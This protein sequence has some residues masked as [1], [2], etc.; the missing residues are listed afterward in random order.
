MNVLKKNTFSPVQVSNGLDEK[1]KR[2]DSVVWKKSV[3]GLTAVSLLATMASFLLRNAYSSTFLNAMY[4]SE[5]L[6]FIS[7]TTI[8][9]R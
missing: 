8:T 7:V 6:D 1:S 4:S 5:R 3:N 2:S 9:L